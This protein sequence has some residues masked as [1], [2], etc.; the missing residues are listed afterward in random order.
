[1]RS[2]YLDVQRESG[3]LLSNLC[4]SDLE[5]I[6][7]EIFKGGGHHILISFLLSV[8]NSCQHVGSFGMGNLCTHKQH[9]V[10]LMKVGALEPLCTWARSDDVDIEIQR[11]CTLAIANLACAIENHVYY[12]EENAIPLLISLSD[13][14]DMLVRYYV[15]LVLAK[16]VQNATFGKLITAEGGLDP[17]LPLARTDNYHAHRDILRAL[18][19]LSFEQSNKSQVYK[20]GGLNVKV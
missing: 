13:S 16:V 7:E 3:R 10:T 19:T 15:S 8:D 9:H 11:F 5:Q 6:V 1:M 2:M 18:T 17:V 14:S 12:I 4:A 20:N